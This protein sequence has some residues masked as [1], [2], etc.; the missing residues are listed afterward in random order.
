MSYDTRSLPATLKWMQQELNA[1][2]IAHERGAGLV[3]YYRKE[4]S[5]T[6]PAGKIE[7]ILTATALDGETTPFMAQLAISDWSQRDG[8][9]DGNTTDKSV[10]W[11]LWLEGYDDNS[12]PVSVDISGVIISTANITVSIEYVSS[13]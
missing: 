3:E 12:N 5:F 1:L 10:S 9:V 8:T 6:S 4:F 7:A 2:K 11:P 13:E